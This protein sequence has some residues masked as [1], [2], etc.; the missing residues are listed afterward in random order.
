MDQI[1]IHRRPG[2][3]ATTTVLELTGPLTLRTLVDVQGALRE[4]GYTDTIL[5]LSEVPFI[6]SAG[7]GAIINQ[8]ER[9]RKAGE[10]FAVVGASERVQALFK[11]TKVDTLLP[12]YAT[13][14]EGER[15]FAA[16]TT[17]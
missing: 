3:L 9:A 12:I 16:K 10:K 6:D 4:P 2:K 13:S 8:S 5:D 17:P 7:L 1:R 15:S 11:L 14:E